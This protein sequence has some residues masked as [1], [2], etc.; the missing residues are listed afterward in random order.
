V[1]FRHFSLSA[2]CVL[3]LALAGCSCS[4]E[5]VPSQSDAQRAVFVDE[6]V[7]KLAETYRKQVG[8]WPSTVEEIIG[9]F[10]TEA[11]AL[12]YPSRTR[13]PIT[14]ETVVIHKIR[15]SADWCKYRL[16]IYGVDNTDFAESYPGASDAKP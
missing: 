7:M 11:Y 3:P 4:S 15:E 1:V 5:T 6:R 12:D 2:L 16:R 13:L 9:K 8:K 14:P 10:P